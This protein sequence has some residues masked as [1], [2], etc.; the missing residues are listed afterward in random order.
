MGCSR[1]QQTEPGI[2]AISTFTFND[3]QVEKTQYN[4]KG[5]HHRY[6]HVI[7][8]FRNQATV[9]LVSN[10]DIRSLG[11]VGQANGPEAD[12][13]FSRIPMFQPRTL[14]HSFLTSKVK[15]CMMPEQLKLT[16]R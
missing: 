9:S 13:L 16:R 7:S 3:S 10:D 11:Q 1:S 5:A 14:S 4:G 15:A 8:R 12:R 6:P 2:A